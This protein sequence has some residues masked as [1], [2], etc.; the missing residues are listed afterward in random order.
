MGAWRQEHEEGSMW[1]GSWGWEHGDRSMGTAVWERAACGWV[2]EWKHVDVSVE[3][4]VC[5]EE[6]GDE[7]MGM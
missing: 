2:W 6:Y 7:S 5:Q 4:G 3:I 1:E